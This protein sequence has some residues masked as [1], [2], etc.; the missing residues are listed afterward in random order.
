MWNHQLLGSVVCPPNERE[1]KTKRISLSNYDKHKQVR[2]QK[3]HLFLKIRKNWHLCFHGHVHQIKNKSK[4]KNKSFNLASSAGIMQE[5]SVV[6]HLPDNEKDLKPL[7]IRVCPQN[8]QQIKQTKS[9][10]PIMTNIKLSQKTEV[11]SFLWIRMNWN[12][13]CSISAMF[14]KSKTNQKQN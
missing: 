14:A 4:P 3:F 6:S 13:C 5:P 9:L 11:S 2:K 8:K 7:Q 10:F 1:I 12:L